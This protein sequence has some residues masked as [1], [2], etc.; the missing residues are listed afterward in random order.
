MP[1]LPSLGTSG[2][3]YTTA[4]GARQQGCASSIDGK[5]AYGLRRSCVSLTL[6]GCYLRQ[7]DDLRVNIQ[8]LGCTG[9]GARVVIRETGIRTP[10]GKHALQ[11]FVSSSVK[12]ASGPRPGNMHCS[13][14]LTG[15]PI[16][17]HPGGGRE[18]PPGSGR[19]RTAVRKGEGK[20]QPG[21]GEHALQVFWAK[22][23]Y[24]VR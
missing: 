19:T 18:T 9:W 22:D 7:A 5:A 17:G 10:T 2:T 20:P 4:T 1:D 6:T 16:V 11:S 21:T 13:P 8:G 15:R 12:R 3:G 23:C 14:P 24:R